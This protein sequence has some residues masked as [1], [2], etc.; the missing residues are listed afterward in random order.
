MGHRFQGKNSASPLRQGERI[1]VG[2]SKLQAFR[3]QNPH[4]TLSLWE[5]RGEKPW[6]KADHSE[7]QSPSPSSSSNCCFRSRRAAFLIA[8]R[9]AAIASFS[10]WRSRRVRGSVDCGKCLIFGRS[11]PTFRSFGFAYGSMKNL[12][13][14]GHELTRIGRAR[15]SVRAAASRSN[16][17]TVQSGESSSSFGFRHC[18]KFVSIRVHSW[19]ANENSW[20]HRRPWAG[21]HD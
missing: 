6:T 11:G 17:S 18:I 10:A 3:Q 7:L 13:T 19:L 5:G 20:D 16:V 12:T 14:N 1:E 4:P 9:S 2:G 21:E 8:R 15:H